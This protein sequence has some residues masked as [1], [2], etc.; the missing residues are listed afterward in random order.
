VNQSLPAELRA[1]DALSFAVQ[2]VALDP[3]TQLFFVLTGIVRNVP[4]RIQIA[5]VAIDDAGVASFTIASATT[6]AW[7]PGRY[8]W[9]CFALD[10]SSNRIQLAQ[11]QTRISPD[12]AGANPA[13]PRTYNQ[14]LLDAIRCLIEGRTQDDIAMYKIGGREITRLAPMDLLKWEGIIEV[15]VRRER[16]RRGEKLPT[17]VIGITFGGR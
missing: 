7:A 11:G 4:T 3:G 12:P 2:T 15:R 17:K 6:A 1:G 8:E 14:R 9:V 16:M 5:A 10:A 13:D